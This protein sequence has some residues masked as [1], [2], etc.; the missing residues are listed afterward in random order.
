[1]KPN[2]FPRI[3]HKVNSRRVPMT[4]DIDVLQSIKRGYWC[5]ELTDLATGKVFEVVGAECT[6][7]NCMC[8]ARITKA[9]I[10]D[11]SK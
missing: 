4:L 7:P 2:F 11:V 10:K 9:S 6:L 8:D 1:M 5:K 3:G